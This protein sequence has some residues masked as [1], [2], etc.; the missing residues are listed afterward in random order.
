[1]TFRHKRLVVAL[2][3]IGLGIV[4]LSAAFAQQADQQP[5]KIEKIEVTG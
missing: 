4:T 5:Q 2:S 1:M 3:S